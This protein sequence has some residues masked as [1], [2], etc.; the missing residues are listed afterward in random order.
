MGESFSFFFALPRIEAKDHICGK[1][2]R[3]RKKE[4]MVV[5][6]KERSVSA[7]PRKE[8]IERGNRKS[9]AIAIRG[10]APGSI[11]PATFIGGGC[12]LSLC[13]FFNPIPRRHV[14]PLS[15]VSSPFHHRP[16]QHPRQSS[17]SSTG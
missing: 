6:K 2:R 15:R 14:L 16:S 3:E 10:G 17:T 8:E 9:E 12:I 5:V 4:R 13:L 1:T 7:E 11:W